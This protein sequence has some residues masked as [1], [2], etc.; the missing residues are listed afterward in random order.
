MLALFLVGTS[1]VLTGCDEHHCVQEV[2]AETLCTTATPSS[3]LPTTSVSG[4][5]VETARSF[6]GRFQWVS[7]DLL[8]GGNSDFCWCAKNGTKVDANA[9]D[10]RMNCWEMVLLAGLGSGKIDLHTIYEE[11]A[12]DCLYCDDERMV[13]RVEE[14]L[15]YD[16]AIL[17]YDGDKIDML[18]NLLLVGGETIFFNRLDWTPGHVAL[19]VGEGDKLVS[20]WSGPN[21]INSVQETT[22]GEIMTWQ[23]EEIQAVKVGYPRWWP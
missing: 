15:G 1:G 17:V 9:K 4:D 13:D 14:Y 23:G 3:T 8:G 12:S 10:A 22:I 16:G 19:A 2:A 7:L 11:G 5:V 18:D 21:G 20:L 6:V